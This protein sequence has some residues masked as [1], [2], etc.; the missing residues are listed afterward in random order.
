MSPAT[1]HGIICPTCGRKLS[2]WVARFG[3]HAQGWGCRCFVCLEHQGNGNTEAEAIADFLAKAK[4]AK[5][6]S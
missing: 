6:Q 3:E 1:Q 4:P 2:T 5:A